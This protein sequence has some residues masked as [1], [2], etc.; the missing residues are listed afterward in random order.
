MENFNYDRLQSNE[1]SDRFPAS[2]LPYWVF[3]MVFPVLP[4]KVFSSSFA[5]VFEVLATLHL[6][7]LGSPLCMKP[8]SLAQ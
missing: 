7:E 5:N 1:V 3:L 8:E 2:L 4:Q 6:S